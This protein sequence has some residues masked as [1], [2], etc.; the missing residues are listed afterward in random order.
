[1]A[2]QYRAR[3]FEAAWISLLPTLSTATFKEIAELFFY[4][5]RLAGIEATIES[6]KKAFERESQGTDANA[7]GSKKKV[8]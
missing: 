5:G 6:T 7:G 2:K 1:M 4:K 3:D 8:T